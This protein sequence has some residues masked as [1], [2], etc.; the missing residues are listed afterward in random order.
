MLSEAHAFAALALAT[1]ELM[2]DEE[3]DEHKKLA[4]AVARV[5]DH[6]DITKFVG[7]P[8]HPLFG[9]ARVAVA[10][11]IPRL[12]AIKMRHAA[13]RAKDVTPKPQSGLAPPPPRPEA[14]RPQ[15]PPVA[16]TA[17]QQPSRSPVASPPSHIR[18]APIPG[19]E[20]ITIDVPIAGAGKPN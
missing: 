2:L 17:P 6:Y 8:S 16:Q 12:I 10:L 20:G 7:L 13:E 5:A 9:L 14:P 11:Y 19:F 4:R 3:K 18:A 1:P 15:A